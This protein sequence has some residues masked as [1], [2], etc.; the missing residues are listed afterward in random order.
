LEIF[1]GSLKKRRPDDYRKIKDSILK[2]GIVVP[3]F[4][5]KNEGHNWVIDGTGRIETLRQMRDAG[6]AIPELPVVFIRARDEAEAKEI[7]LKITSH[8]GKI[9]QAGFEEFIKGLDIDFD[10]LGLDIL[11]PRDIREELGLIPET[12]K[13]ALTQPGDLY[14][15]GAHRLI[16]GDCADP[17]TYRRL[18]GDERA[19]M[20]FTDP[21][22]GVSIGDKNK[23]LNTKAKGK[24]YSIEE[25]IEND[26]LGTEELSGLLEKAFTLMSGYMKDSAAYYIAAPQGENGIMMT[27]VLL[28]SG[29]PV[30][31]QLVWCKN[32]PTFSMGR[33]DYDYQHELILYGWKK[34]HNF[35]GMGK[36]TTS[37]WHYN[38]PNKD[39]LHPTMKPP[40]LIRNA[41]ENSM[42]PL[43]KAETALQNSSV[44][45]D[46]ILDTFA[47]S[48]STL[49]AAQ[50]CKR[51]SRLI[52]IDPHYCDVI[53][54]RTLEAYPKLKPR[55]N[56][57]D[58]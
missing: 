53:V 2:H 31:H 6:Q 50:D 23:L 28:Q 12:P 52:E 47:G 18:M 1:Q 13:K 48:G 22:Y 24:R 10:D 41:I 29:L 25:N 58:V 37:L 30:R 19:D 40:E 34:T 16:C 21:P 51:R 35:Y 56:T 5:W 4:I 27:R 43:D 57:P 33:L 39:D 15:I 32:A 8:Y 38:K 3:L 44:K 20:V 9:S 45:N 42:E 11:P 17:E 49:I 36:Y 14:T 26:T 54:K 46:I 55:L 7:L